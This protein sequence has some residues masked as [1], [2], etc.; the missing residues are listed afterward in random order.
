[1]LVADAC[2][3]DKKCP[4]ADVNNAKILSEIG[5]REHRLKVND[6]LSRRLEFFFNRL[7]FF[8]RPV[9]AD[10]QVYLARAYGNYCNV[11]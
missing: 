3:F 4:H 6:D 10:E 2:G 11:P 8:G 5:G 9:R 7:F 1:M